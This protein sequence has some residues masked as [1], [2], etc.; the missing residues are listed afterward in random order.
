MIESVI[1]MVEK[2]LL[3]DIAAIY[4]GSIHVFSNKYIY[5][6]WFHW[7][8]LTISLVQLLAS[9]DTARLFGDHFK[10]ISEPVLFWQLMQIGGAACSTFVAT[11]FY[12]VA[13]FAPSTM[14]E[15]FIVI[16]SVLTNENCSRLHHK[17][18]RRLRLVKLSYWSAAIAVCGWE[19][20][21]LY[22]L[23][24]IGDIR[25][26]DIIWSLRLPSYVYFMVATWNSFLFLF[27]VGCD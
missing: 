2:H 25:G 19:S 3:V 1:N 9:V 6:L 10:Y 20:V 7:F 22:N 13:R 11:L 18:I 17:C 23:H 12:L 4:S 26:Y 24:K 5:V 16:K 8:S 14:V 21:A 15:F 27:L